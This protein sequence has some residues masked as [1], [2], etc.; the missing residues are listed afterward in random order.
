MYLKV[1]FSF[2]K[3]KKAFDRWLV[4]GPPSGKMVHYRAIFVF[5]KVNF[6]VIWTRRPKRTGILGERVSN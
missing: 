1:S 4:T 5:F 2:S 3:R 6:E